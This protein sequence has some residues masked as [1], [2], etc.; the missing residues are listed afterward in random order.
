MKNVRF[1]KAGRWA[2]ESVRSPQFMVEEGEV[3]E[4][5]DTVADIVVGAG[6]GE[7]VEVEVESEVSEPTENP[8]TLLGGGSK[9][10]ASPKEAD[11]DG[12]AKRAAPWVKNSKE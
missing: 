5:H 3:K 10:D 6:A 1:F 12:T 2:G 7:I 11:G 9:S 4:V 8:P